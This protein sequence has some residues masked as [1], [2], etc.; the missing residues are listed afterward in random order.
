MSNHNDVTD[1]SVNVDN[2]DEVDDGICFF[3]FDDDDDFVLTFDVIFKVQESITGSNTCDIHPSDW[4][5][6]CRHMIGP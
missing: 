1:D 2:D 3:T 4:L 5:H 6:R